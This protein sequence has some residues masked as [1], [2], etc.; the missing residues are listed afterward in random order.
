MAPT[1][2]LSVSPLCSDSRV[3]LLLM[4]LSLSLS[5]SDEPVI[6][7]LIYAREGQIYKPTTLVNTM[8][9]ELVEMLFICYFQYHTKH[10][11]LG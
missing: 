4:A 11:G 3:L 8:H 10:W 7:S 9:S 1:T 5:L 6:T 2:C